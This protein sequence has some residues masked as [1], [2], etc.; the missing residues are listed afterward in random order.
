MY[1][2][3]IYFISIYKPKPFP[4]YMETMGIVCCVKKEKKK[5]ML[6]FFHLLSRTYPHIKWFLIENSLLMHYK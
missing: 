6:H 4:V 1:A 2:Y 3:K 5:D